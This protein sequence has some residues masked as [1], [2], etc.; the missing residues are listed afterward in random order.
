MYLIK[1]DWTT[2][3][4]TLMDRNIWAT[5]NDITNTE[6]RG[7][8]YK[9]WNNHWFTTNDPKYF[10]TSQPVGYRYSWG[11]WPCPNGYYIPSDNEFSTI[12]SD[13][14]SSKS[15]LADNK[16]WPTFGKD[17][18]LS[19]AGYHNV[20]NYT[21]YSENAG[22]YWSSSSSGNSRAYN[23]YFSQYG[24]SKGTYDKGYGLS[25]RCFKNSQTQTLALHPDGWTGAVIAF[26]G[27]AWNGTFTTL[28][29]PTRGIDRFDGWYSDSN[30]ENIVEKWDLVTANLYAKWTRVF[31]VTFM[32][33]GETLNLQPTTW[34]EGSKITLPEA[35]E[36]SGY[37]FTGWYKESTFENKWNE[38]TDTI[39]WNTIIYA[40]YSCDTANHYVDDEN[41]G[42][43]LPTYTVTFM[44]REETLNLQPTTGAYGLTITLPEAPYKTGYIFD[45]WYKESTFENEWNESTDVVTWDTILYAKYGCDT[46]RNYIDDENGGCKCNSWLTEVNGI[47]LNNVND[48]NTIISQFANEGRTFTYWEISISRPDSISTGPESYII[49][50]RNLWATSSWTVCD[51]WSNNGTCGLLYQYW[52]NYWYSYG[53][54][55]MAEKCNEKSVD[56]RDYSPSNPYYDSTFIKW[57]R[58]CNNAGTDADWAAISNYNIWWWQNGNY[59][60]RQWPC[61]NWWH[62][63][64][65]KEWEDVVNYWTVWE[66]DQ[67]KW[68]LNSSNINDFRNYFK[69]PLAWERGRTAGSISQVWLQWNYDTTQ[70]NNWAP[71]IL[72]ISTTGWI[73][74]STT[75]YNQ[76]NWYSVRCF[77]NIDEDK[78]TV[79]FENRNG[80]VLWSTRVT[81]GETPVYSWIPSRPS[82]E[83]SVYTFDKRYPE[84]GPVTT[85]ITYTATFLESPR[86]YTIT[87][88][89]TPTW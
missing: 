77:K 72:R 84:I 8:Y 59:T 67:W 41:G 64:T 51:T 81:S 50:D 34:L 28:D 78:Y 55:N 15:K 43:V 1:S 88:T 66:S 85:D 83:E 23:I 27:T 13:W 82:S 57:K 44:D 7:Y 37:I 49:M 5:T 45:T 14:E 75:N 11:Q 61:P 76:V 25:V 40:K 70:P 87:L 42:C 35:L 9:W 2:G 17:W 79:T 33:G 3:H 46:I 36:K 22:Y 69:L 39:T 80:D 71:F 20:V 54:I 47:C 16:K 52:N 30:Y 4:Y 19:T 60:D 63:P 89:W 56:L 12:I 6:S 58:R 29:N 48:S 32:D 26:T 86:L 31:T 65:K 73:V 21:I 68:V 38:S 10:S 53:N 74:N 24:L 18:L 62:I